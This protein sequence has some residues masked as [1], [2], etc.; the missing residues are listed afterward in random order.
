[1]RLSRNEDLDIRCATARG[2]PLKSCQSLRQRMPVA[3]YEQSFGG[4]ESASVV[5]VVLPSRLYGGK[6]IFLLRFSGRGRFDKFIV[7]HLGG[8]LSIFMLVDC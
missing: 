4:A 8:C 2:P 1:M 6:N 3:I 5:D 7:K